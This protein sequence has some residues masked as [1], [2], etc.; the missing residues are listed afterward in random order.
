MTPKD[1]IKG[2]RDAA[3]RPELLEAIKNPV[4]RDGI[5][6]IIP[7]SPSGDYRSLLLAML[8]EELKYRAQPTDEFEQEEVDCT[9]NIYLCAF[10]LGNIGEVEDALTLWSAKHLNMDVGTMLD[11]NYLV[12]AGIEPTKRY[13]RSR[14]SKEAEDALDYL[15]K[16]GPTEDE[17][18][19]WFQWQLEYFQRKKQT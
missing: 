12:G 14:A 11:G 3:S 13:L 8:A 1:A 4:T 18:N 9:D 2:W 5:Y 7:D 17:R 10:L 6:K 15:E 19:E 16:W